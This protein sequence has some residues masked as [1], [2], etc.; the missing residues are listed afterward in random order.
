M[1]HNADLDTNSLF[2]RNCFF[3]NLTKPIILKGYLFKPQIKE[4]WECIEW[5]KENWLNLF[6]DEYYPVQFGRKVDQKCLSNDFQWECLNL[7]GEMT[8]EELLQWEKGEIPFTTS[9]KIKV[10]HEEYWLYLDYYYMKNLKNIKLAEKI[11]SW[12]SLGFSELTAK[13]STIWIGTDGANTPCHLDTYGSNIVCQIY[14]KKRW[15]LFPKEQSS[16][17]YPTRIPYEESSIY[18]EICFQK[19]NIRK[20][21]K[22]K[23]TSPFLVTLEAGD[24]LLV[25]KHWWHFVENLDFA[26]SINTWVPMP[27]DPRDRLKES[28]VLF[29]VGSLS[30]SITN[31]SLLRS[32][33][34]TNILLMSSSELLEFLEQKI[35]H[36][37]IEQEANETSTRQKKQELNAMDLKNNEAKIQYVPNY[38][39]EEYCSLVGINMPT[40]SDLEKHEEADSHKPKH[41]KYNES[42]IAKI[43]IKSF[44]DDRVIEVLKNVL[45]ENLKRL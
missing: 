36:Y 18:S 9:T 11:T 5:S 45:D 21:S 7:R 30:Q 26:I 19:P 38:N 3:N 34:H 41:S 44:T 15:T 24:V 10:T 28:L 12:E 39:F 17:L 2:L 27:T 32:I 8:F 4:K 31:T 42:D 25:P 43:L 13:D 35:L 16:Y 40:A 23:F 14:G 29:Q 37:Q 20:F 6:K 33:F 22:L 1:E